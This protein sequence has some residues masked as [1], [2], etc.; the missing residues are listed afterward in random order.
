VAELHMIM[1]WFM[2]SYNIKLIA[3]I[4]FALRMLIKHKLKFRAH[5]I[6]SRQIFNRMFDKSSEL[7]STP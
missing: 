3:K 6:R 1:D 5:N 2:H 7:W 4:P